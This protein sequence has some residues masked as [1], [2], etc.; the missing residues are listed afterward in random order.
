MIKKTILQQTSTKDLEIPKK[1]E[2]NKYSLKLQ[3]QKYNKSASWA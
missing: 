1:I 2:H 3:A